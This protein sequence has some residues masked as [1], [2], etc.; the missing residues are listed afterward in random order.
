MGILLLV[1]TFV[2][3]DPLEGIRALER[4]GT[5]GYYYGKPD[6]MALR[7]GAEHELLSKHLRADSSERGAVDRISVTKNH[8]E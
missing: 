1:N 5:N 3:P 7:L 4:V 6:E 2:F 8:H